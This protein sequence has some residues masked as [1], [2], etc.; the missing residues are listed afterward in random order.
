ME[1]ITVA[2]VMCES[3]E[4]GVKEFQVSWAAVLDCSVKF[5]SCV[6]IG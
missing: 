2:S 6:V 4:F 1:G 3:N 5:E